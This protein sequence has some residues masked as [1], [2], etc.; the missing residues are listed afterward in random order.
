MALL[1]IQN[2]LS[3]IEKELD[4]LKLEETEKETI[5]SITTPYFVA[6]YGCQ[7][8]FAAL[9]REYGMYSVDP[10]LHELKDEKSPQEREAMILSTIT[11][12]NARLTN[13]TDGLVSNRASI[14]EDK[15]LG[16]LLVLMTESVGNILQLT[17]DIKAGLTTLTTTN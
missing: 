6:M 2:N 11:E 7:E 5:K 16:S 13:Y 9:G 14:G 17:R 15:E 3:Y 12:H 8:E 10:T 1:N 4:V